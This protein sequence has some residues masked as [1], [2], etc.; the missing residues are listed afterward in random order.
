MIAGDGNCQF[1]AISDQLFDNVNYAD[2]VREEAVK[3]LR[4]NKDWELPNGAVL[5]HFA[6]ITLRPHHHS[7]LLSISHCS[8][9]ARDSLSFALV[10]L[11]RIVSTVRDLL[12]LRFPL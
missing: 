12:I 9:V 10:F 11:P 7:F 8:L 4:Q 5:W 2:Y 6:C 3:W 1:A